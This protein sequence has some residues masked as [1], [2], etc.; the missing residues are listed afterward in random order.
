MYGGLTISILTFAETLVPNTN[1]NSIT[2]YHIS[3]YETARRY[4]GRRNVTLSHNNHVRVVYTFFGKINTYF[5][6]Y[7][8][9]VINNE[10]FF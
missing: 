8:P 3:N 10:V 5:K 9:I 2:W 7:I 6:L 4:L 1:Y